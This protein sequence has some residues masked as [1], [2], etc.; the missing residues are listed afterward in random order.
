MKIETFR[1]GQDFLDPLNGHKPQQV[2]ILGPKKS[3]PPLK[4]KIF[5]ETPLKWPKLWLFTQQN[6]FLHPKIKQRSVGNFMQMQSF[7]AFWPWL[8]HV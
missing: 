8:L 6:D 2:A 5:M 3:R 7:F 1:G 4:V